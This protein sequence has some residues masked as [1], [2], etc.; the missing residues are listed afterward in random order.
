[1]PAGSA[2][3][4][5]PRKHPA[6][7]PDLAT[8]GHLHRPQVK[9]L[10][11]PA[12]RLIQSQSLI[13]SPALRIPLGRIEASI[14]HA[15]LFQ[16]PFPAFLLRL[17]RTIS[18][19]PEPVPPRHPLRCSKLLS[20]RISSSAHSCPAP[21]HHVILH[22][23]LDLNIPVPMAGPFDQQRLPGGF[24]HASM[25]VWVSHPHADFDLG[26]LLQIPVHQLWQ[27]DTAQLSGPP[28]PS[29]ALCPPPAW[30][31]RSPILFGERLQPSLATAATQRH[32][33][34]QGYPGPGAIK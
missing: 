24:H 5:W 9:R 6:P 30:L 8:L 31:H 12:H 15:A 33:E 16:V 23:R 2:P 29:P 7:D 14:T 21:R 18:A 10:A 27:E 26:V 4:P 13:R 17:V 3:L 20:R 19:N 11:G 22:E 32:P 1:M 28:G 34:V 25:M